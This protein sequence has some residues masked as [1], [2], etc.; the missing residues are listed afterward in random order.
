[1]PERLPDRMSEHMSD[2]NAGKKCQN[3][4]AIYVSRCFLRD[5]NSVTG[6]RSLKAGNS[7]MGLNIEGW[8]TTGTVI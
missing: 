6:W 4:Y 5:Q 1:M 8:C 3:R 2:R 7:L